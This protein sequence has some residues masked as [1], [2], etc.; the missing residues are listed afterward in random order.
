MAE[1]S[2]VRSGVE[3]VPDDESGVHRCGC[4]SSVRG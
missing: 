4:L 3:V 2:A 1:D